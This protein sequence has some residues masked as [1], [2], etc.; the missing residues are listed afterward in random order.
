MARGRLRVY[1]GAAPGVGKTYAML[2]EGHRRAERGTDVVVGFVETHGRRHTAEHGRRAS[3]SCRGATLTYRG[4]TLHRD[5][6]RRGPGAPPAGRPGRRARAHQRARARATRSAGRTSRSCSTPG[7]DVI[8]TV[9]IQHLESLNDVVEKI[10]GVPQRETVPDAVVRAADQVEL[11]DM[12]PEALRRRMAHGNVYAAEQGRR[13]A[14]ATTSGS[15]TSPRCASW[16]C[17]GWPTRS[18]RRW[19]ATAPSTASTSRGRPANASSSRSPAAPEGETLIRRGARIAAR[20]AGRRAAGRARRPLRRA[21]RRPPGRRWPGSGV[22]VETLGGTYHPVVGDDVAEA[23]LDFARAVNAT[24]LVLGVS[25][26]RGLERLFGRGVGDAIVQGSGDIDVHIVTHEQ[27]GRGGPGRRPRALSQRRTWPGGSWR[28]S[29]R[30]CSPACCSG[31][32]R[33]SLSLSS[34]LLL[35]LTLTVGVALVGGLWPA[36][37]GAVVS[38]VVLN[39]VFTPPYGTLTIAEGEN[40]LALVIFVVVAAAVASVVDLAARRTEQ[41]SRAQSE[42]ATLST[43]AGSVL[44]GGDAG[45]G[46]LLDRLRE[47]FGAH[48]GDAARA[49]RGPGRPGRWWPRPGGR[50][51]PSRA[52]ATAR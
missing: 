23:L 9:N 17:C 16:P 29:A 2:G 38:S 45:V 6:R 47:T 42:A 40:I 5:G 43:L 20:S 49:S 26:R 39:W 3:R 30:W 18:T 52:R 19:S 50:R 8:S 41:A 24:Q 31:R 21:H 11:V 34:V 22:L 7:I 48:V 10:T 12:A 14:G 33:E 44:S 27:V 51:A 28:P 32:R 35:F 4:A 15:A 1:L 36:L 25:R 46:P 13:R 37:V